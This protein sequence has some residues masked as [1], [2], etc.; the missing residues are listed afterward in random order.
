MAAESHAG[1]FGYEAAGHNVCVCVGLH[2]DG[3]QS[4]LGAPMSAGSVITSVAE[5]S[6]STSLPEHTM[7]V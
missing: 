5:V 3:M 1:S 2:R 7:T 6:C 4:K